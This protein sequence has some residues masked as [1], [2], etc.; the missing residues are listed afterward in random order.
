M[1]EEENEYKTP[2]AIDNAGGDG[3]KSDGKQEKT[4]GGKVSLLQS[5]KERLRRRLKEKVSGVNVRA[6]IRM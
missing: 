4:E 2:R 6:E 5:S 1:K 3:N